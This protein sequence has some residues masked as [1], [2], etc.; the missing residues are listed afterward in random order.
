MTT[1]SPTIAKG[2]ER[3]KEMKD[4]ALSAKNFRDP[5]IKALAVKANWQPNV[6]VK[7]HETY[8]PIL[9]EMGIANT[10]AHGN[11]PTTGRPWVEQWIG[12]AFRSLRDSNLAE[13][14]ARG[15][16]SLTQKGIDYARALTGTKSITVNISATTVNKATATPVVADEEPESQDD[17]NLGATL[18]L[19]IPAAD[20]GIDPYL[21]TLQAKAAKCLGKWS[22]RATLCM[23]CP[24]TSACKAVLRSDLSALAAQMDREEQIKAQP[25]SDLDLEDLLNDTKAQTKTAKTK[26]GMTRIRAALD[27]VCE[28]CGKKIARG[29]W[30][31]WDAGEGLYHESCVQE[32]K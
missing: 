23:S 24:I 9:A 29:E 27:S 11:Q 8:E 30:C 17:G 25:N 2:N 22:E 18:T 7:F 14:P 12:W 31:Y 1:R 28:T 26:T 6:T 19:D 16:W 32:S 3:L 13:L 20:P 21:K 10:S 4:M 15:K 5:L